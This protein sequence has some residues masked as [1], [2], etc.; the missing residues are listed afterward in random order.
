[1]LELAI[2]S[3]LVRVIALA[4]GFLCIY[5]GYRLFAQIPVKTTNEGQIKMPKFGEVKLKAAPGI[6][7]AAL[8]T[9]IVVWSMT[10]STETTTIDG[11]RKEK[12]ALS[13]P[14]SL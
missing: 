14:L 1:M 5:F 4:V 6:F 12:A 11:T 3:S 10:N 2:L 7:F 9:L 13:L 8:G